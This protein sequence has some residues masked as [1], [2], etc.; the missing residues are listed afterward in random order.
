M[1]GGPFGRILPHEAGVGE[2]DVNAALGVD[3]DPG[4]LVPLRQVRVG[5][6]ELGEEPAGL[7]E[8]L[9][10]Q[11]AGQRAVLAPLG[12]V[13]DVQ[14]ALGVERDVGDDAELAMARPGAADLQVGA[15]AERGISRR[16]GEEQGE[17]AQAGEHSPYRHSST[18]C[19]EHTLP[20]GSRLKGCEVHRTSTL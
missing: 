9:D 7:V 12:P 8:L 2:G 19:Y 16:R 11:V 15:L 10:Q 6:R 1:R 4:R 20:F 3:G 17:K 18:P 5:Q 13:E 14:V